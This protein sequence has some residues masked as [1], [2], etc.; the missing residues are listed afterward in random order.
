MEWQRI[1]RISLQIRACQ[2]DISIP[3]RTSDEC[4]KVLQDY[5]YVKLEDDDIAWWTGRRNFLLKITFLFHHWSWCV[6]DRTVIFPV[7]ETVVNPPMYGNKRGTTDNVRFV[8]NW[9]HIIRMS[10]RSTVR[11]PFCLSQSHPSMN[12]HSCR[13]LSGEGRWD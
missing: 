11:P 3:N 7:K 6:D 12:A 10:T 5:N 2:T 1:E 9:P 8:I 4:K 13:S